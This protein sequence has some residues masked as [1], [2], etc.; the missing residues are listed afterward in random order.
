MKKLKLSDEFISAFCMQLSL[1]LHAGI[2]IGDGL[3]LLEEDESDTLLRNLLGKLANKMDEGNSFSF[4]LKEVDSFPK[5]VVDMTETGEL[6]GRQEQAFQALSAYYDSRIKLKN[7]IKNAILYPVIL[8]ALMVII[9]TILLVKVLPIFNTVYEQL[10]GHMKGIAG[11]LLQIGIFLGHAMPIL[12][13]LLAILFFGIVSFIFSDNLRAFLK[14]KYL[15]YAGH[16]GIARK[17]GTAQFTCA[18]SMGMM[19]GLHE[20]EALQNAASI[21]SEIPVLKRQ[22]D[23]CIQKMQDGMGL[24]QA[25]RETKL[26]SNTYCRMLELGIRCGTADTVIQEIARRLQEETEQQIEERVAKIEPTIV[27]ITSLIVGAILITVMLPL[28]NI[29]SSLG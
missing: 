6:S 20:E 9:I 18:M 13:A 5:Y 12:A 2:S 3:H 29:M 15:K 17:I 27:V 23:S 16:K 7:R 26:L 8:L 10:G 4:A 21:Q 11:G 1:L 25:M 24:A 22:Y 28:M 19:S 14:K